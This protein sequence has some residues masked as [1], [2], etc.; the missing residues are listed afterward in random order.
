MLNPNPEYIRELIEV[1]NASPFPDHMA[2]RLLE[3]AL[4]KAVLE[5]NRPAAIFRLMVL[6]MG[7]CWPP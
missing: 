2:M 5:L 6:F 1:I 3:V 4:D 7:A